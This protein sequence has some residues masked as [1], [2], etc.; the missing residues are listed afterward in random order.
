MDD[1]GSDS[2][3]VFRQVERCS[4]EE[5][6]TLRASNSSDSQNHNCQP[7][8]I[9]NI[10]T[11]S[12]DIMRELGQQLDSFSQE[13]HRNLEE[14]RFE[15][16]NEISELRKDVS[17]LAKRVDN[18]EQIV[19]KEVLRTGKTFSRRD[20]QNNSKIHNRNEN[21]QGFPLANCTP[22]TTKAHTKLK[23]QW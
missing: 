21:H 20:N 19:E 18:L 5:N 23:P 10:E 14:I 2:E 15:M 6:N 3:V 7:E 4:S 13:I 16:K 9:Q 8:N 12:R 11:I 22:I 1:S 17:G